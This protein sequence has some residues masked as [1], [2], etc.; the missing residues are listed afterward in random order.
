[1]RPPREEPGDLGVFEGLVEEYGDRMYSIALRITGSPEE[2]EDAT[3]DALL[4]AYQHRER[5]RG[6]ATLATWL[7]RIVVNGALQR[8]RRRRS[9]AYLEDSGFGRTSVVDWSDDLARRVASDELREM[10][11]RGIGLLPDD[12]RVVLVLRDVEQFSTAE[13]ADILELTEA[14]LKS[15]LHRARVL[16]RQY[17]ADYLEDR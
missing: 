6:E 2:A 3:Q 11:E 14:A 16:L 8:V 9:M 4:T 5:F 13:A 7:Y 17:L 1:M 10:I 12:L 15:R